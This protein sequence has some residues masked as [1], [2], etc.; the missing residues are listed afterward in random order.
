[1]KFR[2][3]NWMSSWKGLVAREY[4]AHSFAVTASGS[5]S[6]CVGGRSECV[7]ARHEQV[8]GFLRFPEDWSRRVK[9]GQSDGRTTTC[10]A[11]L[12]GSSWRYVSRPRADVG[13]WQVDGGAVGAVWCVRSPDDADGGGFATPWNRS[14]ARRDRMTSIGYAGSVWPL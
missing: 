8:E 10:E 4:A 3:R 2:C 5:N 13:A 1:M 11:P 12:A 14:V 7:E 9:V 6:R